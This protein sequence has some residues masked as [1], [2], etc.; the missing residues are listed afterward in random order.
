VPDE[1][2]T[3]KAEFLG[4]ARAPC[5]VTIETDVD[6]N[7][8]AIEAR[9]PAARFRCDDPFGKRCGSQDRRIPVVAALCGDALA[10]D[11]RF[12]D[13]YE[14]TIALWQRVEQVTI[15]RTA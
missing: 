3:W 14:A 10:D 5:R 12:H 13:W 1:V 4:N 6:Q 9:S 7:E 8:F 15:Y 2:A 11:R